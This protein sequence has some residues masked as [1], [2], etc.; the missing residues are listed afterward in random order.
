MGLILN[1][2]TVSSF[3]FIWQQVFRREQRE[4]LERPLEWGLRQTAAGV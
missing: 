3:P 2:L 1:Y 4:Q